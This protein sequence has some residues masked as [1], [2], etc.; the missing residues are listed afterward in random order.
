MWENKV[1]AAFVATV[2]VGFLIAYKASEHDRRADIAALPAVTEAAERWVVR[3]YPNRVHDVA[4]TRDWT[5]DVVIP[6]G[7]PPFRLQCNTSHCALTPGR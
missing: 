4:C 1:I 5:C 7:P 3:A 6:D 2:I